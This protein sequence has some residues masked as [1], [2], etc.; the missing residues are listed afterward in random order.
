MAENAELKE[1]ISD[2]LF[3]EVKAKEEQAE[4]LRKNERL[5]LIVENLEEEK[6]ALKLQSHQLL[7]TLAEM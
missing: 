4:V 2:V 5:Q 1:S 6:D 7:L 3:K